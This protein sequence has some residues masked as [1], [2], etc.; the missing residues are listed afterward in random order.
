MSD[1]DKQFEEYLNGHSELSRRY[2]KL[3]NTE[4]PADLDTAILDE[5]ERAVKVRPLVAGRRRWMLPVSVAATLMI[6]LS[7]VL[8][9][10]RETPSVMEAEDYV[11]VVVP[12][13]SFVERAP[14]PTGE[15]MPGAPSVA[16]ESPD[17]FSRG[18]Q[19]EEQI[20]S[21]ESP[22]APRIQKYAS[23][24]GT[25]EFKKERGMAHRNAASELK[26]EELT[27]RS[28]LLDVESDVADSE[29]LAALQQMMGIVTEYLS[30][31]VNTSAAEMDSPSGDDD[32]AVQRPL[33]SRSSVS[34]EA[35][36]DESLYRLQA[37][38]PAEPEF[39]LRRIAELYAQNRNKDTADALAEFRIT[40][41]DHPVSRALR[42]HGY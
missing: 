5:A 9:I 21:S 11:D 28:G 19:S 7:L 42:E 8:N 32:R 18:R 38:L 27:E 16:V 4:P 15:M 20:T 2:A 14:A 30:P 33:E 12:A 37:V 34:Q 35:F 6:C 22:L 13:D 10:L 39:E 24:T 3:G 17:R 36:V 23:D 31:R 29:Q 40:F 41:P 25:V 26:R 1:G